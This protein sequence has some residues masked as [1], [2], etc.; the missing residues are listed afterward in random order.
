MFADMEENVRNIIALT[1]S[2]S[3]GKYC[4]L[5]LALGLTLVIIKKIEVDHPMNGRHLKQII[6]AW[7]DCCTSVSPSEKWKTFAQVFVDIKE[8]RLADKIVILH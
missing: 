4:D 6:Q 3:P 2:L 5:G 7:I 1:D 8:E